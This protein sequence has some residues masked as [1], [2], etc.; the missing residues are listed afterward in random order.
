MDMLI[1]SCKE[2]HTRNI[3]HFTFDRA[4]N[5]AMLVINE[6]GQKMKNRIFKMK[7]QKV[8]TMVKTFALNKCKQNT[9]AKPE[10]ETLIWENDL[11]KYFLKQ[12]LFTS[13]FGH[14][15]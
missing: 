3:F 5:D 2:L 4:M 7:A 10:V 1:E 14:A 9:Q 6:T 12:L 11:L 13:G 8:F 15:K